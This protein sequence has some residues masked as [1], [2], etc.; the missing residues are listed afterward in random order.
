MHPA[1]NH[2]F[3]IIMPRFPQ[4]NI[5]HLHAEKPTWSYFQ[6]FSILFLKFGIIEL[7]FQYSYKLFWIPKVKS[8]WTKNI[9]KTET[10]QS[11]QRSLLRCCGD[12]AVQSVLSRQLTAARSSWNFVLAEQ[13]MVV[14]LTYCQ[15]FRN[16]KVYMAHLGTII[17]PI[18][19]PS[20][21]WISESYLKIYTKQSSLPMLPIGSKYTALFYICSVS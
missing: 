4:G 8:S 18:R 7:L 13:L 1:P 20:T 12:Y 21:N 5:F 3:I 14:N 15:N 2:H 19:L 17:L 16:S 10:C 11:S 9:G 6:L